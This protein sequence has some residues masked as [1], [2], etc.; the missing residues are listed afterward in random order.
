MKSVINLFIFIYSFSAIADC[1]VMNGSEIVTI[2]EDDQV[3]LYDE[4]KSLQNFHIQDQDGL[5]VCYANATS[6]LL[7]SVLPNNPDVSYTHAA[8]VSSTSGWRANTEWG[9]NSGKAKYLKS[10]EKDFTYGGYICETIAALQKRGGACAQNKSL[11]E[12]NEM[13][14]PHV[15]ERILQSVGKYFDKVN[16]IK[17]NPTKYASF[18]KDLALIVET[19]SVENA[20]YV[21][22]CEES[23][24]T[25][26]VEGAI[27]S[28]GVE[29]AF[30]LL[31]DNSACSMKKIGVLKSVLDSKANLDLDRIDVKFSKEFISKL[32]SQFTSDET[33]LK[34]IYTFMNSKK[35]DAKKTEELGKKVEE[36]LNNFLKTELKLED[37]TCDINA[38]G[39]SFLIANNYDPGASVI[40]GMMF[41]HQREC[42]D[43]MKTLKGTQYDSL[44]NKNQCSDISSISLITNA[45][46]P[47]L[48]VGY[49]LDKAL[50]KSL[51]NPLSLQANQL[52]QILHPECDKKENLIPLDNIACASFSTCDES[53]FKDYANY[54]YGGPANGCH[55][56]ES[57]RSM[58]RIKA[59]NAIKE[60]RA[61]GVSVCTSFLV[62]PSIKTNFCKT[63]G[64]G[65]EGHSM[66][67][68]TV[69]GY[70]C[71]NNKIEYQLT[72]SW[73]S[74]YCPVPDGQLK[75]EVFECNLDKDR[76]PTGKFWVTEDVLVDS[77]KD[78]NSVVVKKK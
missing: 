62:D 61:L 67:S 24:K 26:P 8:L 2:A 76:N 54:V 55:T 56:M 32:K 50:E 21:K 20:N 19:L 4:G 10:P 16:E 13:M 72:N 44:I 22:S 15:Q 18:K 25:L 14:N 9:T 17:A 73:G 65:V 58:M 31:K 51:E 29:A 42:K 12:K 30:E 6:T 71:V 7:K 28:I 68:M 37:P 59:F 77:T 53:G 45:I 33:L 57:A 36:V 5:G 43:E 41:D 46:E 60:N 78:I 66:H 34:D 38:G 11:F 69:S 75:N 70:R 40:Y 52:T 47:L 63:A 48:E 35:N 3:T 27:E 64:N 74:Q 23:K 39:K 49:N 1:N